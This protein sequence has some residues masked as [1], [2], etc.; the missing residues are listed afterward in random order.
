MLSELYEPTLLRIERL[1]WPLLLF[2]P[3]LPFE[4]ERPIREGISYFVVSPSRS[5][6]FYRASVSWL[7]RASLIWF[8]HVSICQLLSWRIDLISFRMFLIV[9]KYLVVSTSVFCFQ[10]SHLPQFLADRI[11]FSSSS[12]LTNVSW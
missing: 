2:F 12:F 10:D 9:A 1:L 6:T 7:D 4:I 8:L 5:C 3:M 11:S